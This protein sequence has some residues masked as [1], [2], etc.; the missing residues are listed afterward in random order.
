[1]HGRAST[2][3]A[4]FLETGMDRYC[5]C[6]TTPQSAA[7]LAAVLG[8]F[9]RFWWLLLGFLLVLLGDFLDPVG[10]LLDFL[11]GPV[12]LLLGILPGPLGFLLGFRPR[13][14]SSVLWR[15]CGGVLGPVELLLEFVLGHPARPSGIPSGIS[16]GTL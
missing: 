5:F 7:W 6:R 14:I 1:M 2:G 11:L 3:W 10:F 12:R 9:S 8:D 4:T 15:S 13:W 16:L